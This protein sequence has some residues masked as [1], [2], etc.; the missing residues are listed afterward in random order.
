MRLRSRVTRR[1]RPGV[2]GTHRESGSFDVTYV[3]DDAG[4]KAV[5]NAGPAR[6]P[7]KQLVAAFMIGSIGLNVTTPLYI[8]FVA[9]VLGAEDQAIFM[10]TFFYLTTFF[11]VPFWVRLANRFGKHKAYIAAFVSDGGPY[12]SILALLPHFSAMANSRSP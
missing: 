2:V 12:W 7:F 1:P 4:Y 6:E 5:P 9:D 3:I 11:A 10:L 8:F